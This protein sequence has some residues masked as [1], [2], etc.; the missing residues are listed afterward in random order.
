[1]KFLTSQ[2]ECAS[3]LMVFSKISGVRN[4]S[5]EDDLVMVRMGVI[6]VIASTCADFSMA[7]KSEVQ[8]R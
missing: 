7:S 5:I 1:M 2:A 6:A 3:A 4:R 8:H